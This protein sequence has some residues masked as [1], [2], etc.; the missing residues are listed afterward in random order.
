M[1]DP[2]N[3]MCVAEIVVHAEIGLL[4]ICSR[5]ER[6]LWIHFELQ[7]RGRQHSVEYPLAP[8]P[9]ANASRG[10][11]RILPFDSDTDAHDNLQIGAVDVG[12]ANDK[13]QVEI[14]R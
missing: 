13:R 9:P 12:A 7:T 3:S 11:N 4:H 2:R 1:I 14:V 10:N 6:Y 5:V 8:H